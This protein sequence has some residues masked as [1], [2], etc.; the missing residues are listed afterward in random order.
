MGISTWIGTKQ[1]DG[2]WKYA[3]QGIAK[4]RTWTRN[5]EQVETYKWI[6]RTHYSGSFWDGNF[7]DTVDYGYFTEAHEWIPHTGLLPPTSEPQKGRRLLD[8]PDASPSF[9]DLCQKL[10]V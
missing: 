3:D 8:T 5:P 9:K 6:E 10:G 1:D 2:Q 7:N 4:K